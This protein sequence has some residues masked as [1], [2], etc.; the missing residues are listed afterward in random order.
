MPA[1]F[2][3]VIVVGMA[4]DVPE[5]IIQKLHREAHYRGYYTDKDDARD[6]KLGVVV[7]DV[8]KLMAHNARKLIIAEERDDARR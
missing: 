7:A 5:T 6:E 1:M 8:G 4:S 2:P 3:L